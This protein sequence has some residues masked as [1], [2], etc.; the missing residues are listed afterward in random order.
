MINLLLKAKHWQLFLITFVI[1]MFFQVAFLGLLIR[2]I[3]KNGSPN[4]ALF[5]G[6][7]FLILFVKTIVSL[8]QYIWCWS[9]VIGLAKKIPDS[10]KP[11]VSR[12]KFM[13]WLLILS[14]IGFMYMIVKF[15]ELNVS[16]N[17][18]DFNAVIP[19]LMI[20][21]YLLFAFFIIYVLT[22]VAKTI[23]TAELQREVTLGDYI[24][25]FF[26]IYFLP[27]GIWFIQPKINNMMKEEIIGNS[28]MDVL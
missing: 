11:N 6:S 27:I 4:L 3:S 14:S 5:Y 23:R 15:V 26:L 13:F 17:S 21:T 24:G 1:P 12:F 8:V 25:E 20:L 19:G 2:S 18:N 16:P 7:F 10:F 28:L 22:L 9:V